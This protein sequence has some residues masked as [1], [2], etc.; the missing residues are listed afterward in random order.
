MI[1]RSG[2]RWSRIS[3]LAARH[4]DDD[5]DDISFGLMK[6]VFANGP[7]DR[8]SIPGRVIPKTQKMLLDVFFNTQHYK[9][10]I[11]GKVEQFRERSWALLYT[12][13]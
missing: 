7:G 8:A 5:D 1:G 6:I 10:L 11:N 9:V 4:D 2:E 3:V 13:V 12:F